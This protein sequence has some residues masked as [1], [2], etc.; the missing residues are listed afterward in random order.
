MPCLE[1]T[2]EHFTCVRPDNVKEE[3][4]EDEEECDCCN[5]GENDGRRRLLW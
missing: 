1:V 5:D 4:A 3:P 2:I